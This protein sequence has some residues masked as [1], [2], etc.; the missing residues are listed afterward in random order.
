MKMPTSHAIALFVSLMSAH[1]STGDED[2]VQL[3]EVSLTH[4]LSKEAAKNPV[5]GTTRSL[6]IEYPAVLDAALTEKERRKKLAAI[7][8]LLWIGEHASLDTEASEGYSYLLL[9]AAEIIGD[10]DLTAAARKHGPRSFPNTRM[11]MEF[12]YGSGDDPKRA[13]ADFKKHFPKFAKFVAS[14][15]GE[16]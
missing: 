16:R 6:G 8:L 1:V 3:P 4:Q 11:Y 15:Q 5:C 13:A 9:K 10:E 14:N 7:G 2:R 12:E